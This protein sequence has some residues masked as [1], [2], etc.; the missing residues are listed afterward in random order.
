MSDDQKE[1]AEFRRTI[2][3]ALI[4]AGI[5]FIAAAAAIVCLVVLAVSLI[6]IVGGI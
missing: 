4:E 2:S 6:N 1:R 5:G 3:L